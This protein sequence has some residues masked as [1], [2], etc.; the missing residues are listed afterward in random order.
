MTES[1]PTSEP[2]DLLFI[3]GCPRSGTTWLQLL[4][5]QHP[6]VRTVNESHLFEHFVGPAL[7]SW[8]ELDDDPR[9]IGLEVVMSR[10]EFVRR[11]REFARDVYSRVAGP[12][13]RVIVDKTPDHAL[14]I[15]EITTLFPDAGVLHMVRDPRDV[16]ASL[17]AAGET[18]GEHWAPR[19]AYRAACTWSKHVREARRGGK[20]ARRYRELRYEDLLDDPERQLDELLEALSLHSPPGF[21]GRAVAET[22]IDRMRSGETDAP[23]DL[24]GEPDGF[25]RKGGSGN[26]REELSR[27]EAASVERLCS[28]L[29]Q[30]LGY[31]PE[32]ASGFPPIGFCLESAR[33][34]V[35][36]WLCTG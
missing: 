19:T 15:Q 27:S 20:L 2:A 32:H 25:V 30:D 10:S 11:H 26:W 21:V 24:G 29:M 36:S 28:G 17:L 7:R 23:W 22:R 4:L 1:R 14:W 8:D 9:E 5:A 31:R 6:R 3:V 12:E 16:T 33:D 13:T 18:W 35:R 34:R